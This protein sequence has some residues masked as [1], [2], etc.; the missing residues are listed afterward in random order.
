MRHCFDGIGRA[1]V[2]TYEEDIRKALKLEFDL[3]HLSEIGPAKEIFGLLTRTYPISG[4]KIDWRRLP[5]AI[6]CPAGDN[7][8]ESARFATFFDQMCSR[9]GLSGPVIYVGDSATDFALAGSVET[10]RRVLSVLIEIPQHHYFVGPNASWCI[11][12][13]MEGDMDFGA[14]AMPPL[15]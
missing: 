10:I 6:E 2:S 13:T 12:L 15:Q 7:S 4:S 1:T 9:F 5:D 3:G 8:S 11:C 14:V